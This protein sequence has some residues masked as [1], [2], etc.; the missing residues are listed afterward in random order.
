MEVLMKT[1]SQLLSTIII[2]MII[3]MAALFTNAQIQIQ[4]LN[5]NHEGI[6]CWDADGSGHEAEA[7]GHIH[8]FGYGSSLYYCASRDF[9]DQ[10][11]GAAMCHFL[12]ELSGFPH[13]VKKLQQFGFTLDQVKV[14]TG[15]FMLNDDKEG[16][17]WFTFNKKHYYNRYEAYYQIELNEEPM[18]SGFINF[19]NIS[20]QSNGNVWNCE[21]NFNKPYNV[22]QNSSSVV[23]K[24]AEV[25][26]GDVGDQELRFVLRCN[27]SEAFYGNGRINGSYFNIISGYLEKGLPELP[28]YGYEHQ[29][30]GIAFWNA[31]GSGPEPQ[32]TG[33]SYDYGGVCY[34]LPYYF[35]S[36]DY[37][38]IDQN[39]NAAL[40]QFK[41]GLKG[42]P[43]LQIQL[44]YRGYNLDELKLKSGL[45]T[46]G[47]D[48]EGVDWSLNANTH[49]YNYYGSVITVEIANEPILQII[50]DTITTIEHLAHNFNWKSNSS[51]SRL[52][53]LSSL[54]S[55]NA[56]YIVQS[57]LK[58]LEGHDVSVYMEGHY[59]RNM[60]VSEGRI[61]GA[62]HEIENSKLIARPMPGTYVRENEAYGV[63]SNDNSPY[64]VMNKLEVPDGEI[65]TIEPGV[66]VLFNTTEMLTIKGSLI[67]E[68]TQEK[69][70][71]FTS[72]NDMIKWG[73]IAW[74]STDTKNPSSL[75]KYCIFENS[76]A[77]FNQ[78]GQYRGGVL[79]IYNYDQIE[80]CHCVFRNN[81][82]ENLGY[83]FQ[84]GGAIMMI[85]SSIRISQSIFHNNSAP[86]GGAL[87]ILKNSEPI[88]DNCLFYYNETNNINGDGGAVLV[89]REC[90]P[91]FVNCTFADNHALK[92]GG[93]VEIERGGTTSFTNCIFWG[94]AADCGPNQINISDKNY[95]KL[96]VLFCDIEKGILGITPDFSGAYVE[97]ID[98][99]PNFVDINGF[100]YV[101]DQYSACINSG[102]L[103]GVFLPNNWCC[104]ENCLCGNPRLM[105]SAIDLGCYEIDIIKSVDPIKEDRVALRIFP[106]PIN[107]NPSI[108]F[109]LN[110]ENI[111]QLSILD[112]HGKVIS[113]MESQKLQKGKNQLTWNAKSMAPGV[114]FC[115]LQIGNKVVT[116]KLV[117]LN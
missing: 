99:N 88:I 70:I 4:G 26:L 94:N 89:W 39:K 53:V 1:K 2:I 66:E 97:S 8:P 33:H 58:D 40:G 106:N 28:F 72:Y 113:E 25:F 98:D 35:A 104:P 65:L 60:N 14:K 107:S 93:A 75:L 102:T 57:L 23:Q 42:F 61:N 20:I 108:E 101:P 76:N 36:C 116:T 10:S 114:Y 44:V 52:M 37:D 18:I 21:S 117:K 74:P 54:G 27:A 49:K 79:W 3:L 31:D 13:F 91:H 112:I 34:L 109:Y 110:N 29:H 73:G 68:G 64:I 84:A 63:W 59:Q 115:R 67:A 105:G 103:L 86:W 6:A 15:L 83:N 24:I 92:E 87:A 5:S 9:V 95:S 100:H 12:E 111:V 48:I 38:G 78:Y 43:N 82:V 51:I 56:Q 47:N 69:K 7:Y 22:S 81:Q 46:L 45:G 90:N 41:N 85:E 16:E 62:L 17:D 30:Q 19:F 55:R 77:Y 50:C 96:N 32:A 80:I 71:H 11:H